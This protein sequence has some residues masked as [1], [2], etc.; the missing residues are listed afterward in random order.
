VDADIEGRSKMT[1]A[2]LVH[3]LERHSDRETAR[4]RA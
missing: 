3:A 4:A 2:E 1:K